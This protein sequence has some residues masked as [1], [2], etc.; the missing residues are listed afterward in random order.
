MISAAP[1]EQV[2]EMRAEYDSTVSRPIRS[3]A[4]NRDD[5]AMNGHSMV[6]S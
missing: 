3:S 2:V 1:R 6:E 4:E 5:E